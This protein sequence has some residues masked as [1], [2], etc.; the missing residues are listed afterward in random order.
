MAQQI[1]EHA[2]VYLANPSILT[3]CIVEDK[4]AGGSTGLVWG[5]DGDAALKRTGTEPRGIGGVAEVGQ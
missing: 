3:S 1:G 4:D 2:G 5:L